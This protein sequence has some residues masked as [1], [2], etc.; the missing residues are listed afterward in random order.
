[1]F[2]TNKFNLGTIVITPMAMKELD[3]MSVIDSL[4]RH[5]QGDWGEVSEVDREENEVSLKEGLR[6]LSVYHDTHG[7]KFWIIT[8]SDRS[9]TTI[10]LPSDY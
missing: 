3:Q 1:M 5:S 9:A 8:E 7:I 2:S 10:L 4:N 6:L